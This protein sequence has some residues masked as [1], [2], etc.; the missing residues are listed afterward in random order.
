MERKERGREGRREVRTEV[1][2]C[3]EGEGK[4]MGG[5]RENER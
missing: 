4:V 2:N 1:R 5:G 3:G